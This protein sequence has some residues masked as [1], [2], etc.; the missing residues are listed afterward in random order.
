M[1]LRGVRNVEAF[2]WL[3]PRALA[4]ADHGPSGEF[5]RTGG[6]EITVARAGAN[7]GWPDAWRCDAKRG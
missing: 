3:D 6:D 7:P 1:F 4:V 5:G 2:D